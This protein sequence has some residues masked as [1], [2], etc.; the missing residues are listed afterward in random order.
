MKFMTLIVLALASATSIAE[1][2]EVGSYL[3][4]DGTSLDI[5]AG[6]P[7]KLRWRRP[8]GRTGELTSKGKGRWT[9]TLGWTGQP[10]GHRVTIADC[11]RGEIRFD[12]V[13]GRRV[14]LIQIDTRFQGSGVTL[15][16]RLTLPPGDARVPIVVL[17]HGA[18]QSSA[19]K[20]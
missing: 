17:I 7:D 8:D 10:D 9:S 16:G 1:P 4:T 11:K 19:L 6:E 3:M 20:D 5:A 15:A 2:C 14:P 13:V 12:D 18:E